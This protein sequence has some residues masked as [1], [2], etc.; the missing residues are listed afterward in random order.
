MRPL[1]R[2]SPSGQKQEQKEGLPPFKLKQGSHLDREKSEGFIC[3]YSLACSIGILEEMGERTL[4]RVRVVRPAD[5][6]RHLNRT[7][8]SCTERLAGPGSRVERE[9]FAGQ[10]ILLR[11]IQYGRIAS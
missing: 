8:F 11:A 1:Y 5:G 3:I 2:S 7:P 4:G 10:P 9:V 6:I